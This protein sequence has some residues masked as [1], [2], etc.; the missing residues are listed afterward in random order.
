MINPSKNHIGLLK[1]C[2]LLVFVINPLKQNNARLMLLLTIKFPYKLN[3]NSPFFK[4]CVS[5]LIFLIFR[6][7]L[8]SPNVIKKLY[9]LNVALYTYFTFEHGPHI[10]TI[11]LDYHLCHSLSCFPCFYKLISHRPEK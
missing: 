4:K 5:L 1:F 9:T 8:L 10:S 7:S 2:L 3:K 6:Y 11:P